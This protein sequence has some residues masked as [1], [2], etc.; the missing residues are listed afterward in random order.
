MGDGNLDVIE[1]DAFVN[2]RDID[3][4][5]R[6]GYVSS[7]G[8]CARG[9]DGD[10]KDILGCGRGGKRGIDI[11]PISGTEIDADIKNLGCVIV[12][13][14]SRSEI[15]RVNYVDLDAVVVAG[16]R[17]GRNLDTRG[18][19]GSGSERESGGGLLR[20]EEVV[21]SACSAWAVTCDRDVQL[22]GGAE[23]RLGD[24]QVLNLRNG[25]GSC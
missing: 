5:L 8:G 19:S 17:L 25:L 6:H 7:S 14:R 10:G 3:V 22:A 9:I 12:E 1:V 16:I 4:R 11:R 18:H 21:M 24:V 13:R 15:A 20:P 2:R 23:V